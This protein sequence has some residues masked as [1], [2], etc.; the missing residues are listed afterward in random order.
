MNK[1]N[2]EITDVIEAQR[3]IWS[4]RFHVVGTFIVTVTVIMCLAMPF[5]GLSAGLAVRFLRWAMGS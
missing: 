4:M 5:I 2:R 3:Q 1:L